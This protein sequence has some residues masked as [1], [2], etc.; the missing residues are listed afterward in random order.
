MKSPT[1]VAVEFARELGWRV[2]P[3]N[4]NNKKPLISGWQDKASNDPDEIKRLFARWP[5]PMVAIPTG[6]INGITVVDI[7][8]REDKDGFQTLEE[9]GLQRLSIYPAV[10]TPS[11][12]VHLYISTGKDYYRNSASDLGPG[13]DIRSQGGYV[14]GAGSVSVDGSYEWICDFEK[15]RNNT[16]PMIHELR[17]LLS[18][19]KPRRYSRSASPVEKKLLSPVTQGSRNTELARRCGFLLKKY[20]PEMVLDMMLHINKT[21]FNPQ[22]DEREVQSVFFS[23]RKREGV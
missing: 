15:V 17:A 22:L 1:K 10:R 4:P 7:D 6:Q 12:G 23:I 8:V 3:A 9:L 20:P 19:T 18:K 14:I 16:Y 21:C 2:F 11:G 13:I 5:K